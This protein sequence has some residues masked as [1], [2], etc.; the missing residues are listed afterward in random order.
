MAPFS[1]APHAQRAVSHGTHGSAASGGVVAFL[2]AL[3]AQFSP[4]FLHSLLWLQSLTSPMA[5]ESANKTRNVLNVGTTTT[6]GFEAKS[7]RVCHQKERL[8][9]AH[10]SSDVSQK[11]RSRTAHFPPVTYPVSGCSAAV[12]S[13][14]VT[15]AMILHACARQSRRTRAPDA[16][17]HST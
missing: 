11:E 14:S 2:Q 13:R 16:G 10:F 1:L 15:C 7:L 8:Q 9:T 12:C 5:R 4:Q 17:D 6:L 3:F